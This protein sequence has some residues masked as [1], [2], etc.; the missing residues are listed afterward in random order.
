MAAIEIIQLGQVSTYSK[1]FRVD[2]GKVLVISSFNFQCEQTNEIGEVIR[3]AD[4]AILHKIEM[5]GAEIPETDGCPCSCIL[6]GLEASV[7][8]SEPVVQCG[9]NWTHNAQT[10]LTVLSVPGFY[11]FE[12]CNADSIGNISMKVEELDVSDATLIPK[13]LFHGEC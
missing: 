6:E 1:P 11:M 2:V 10:N 7:L 4:C 9:G 5:G 13:Q 3:P 12:V 8:S